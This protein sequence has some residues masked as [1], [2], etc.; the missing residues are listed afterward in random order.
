[1]SGAGPFFRNIM[2]FME[3]KSSL[4]YSQEST[5]D[6]SVNQM[7]LAQ[8]QPPYLFIIPFFI[9]SFHLCLSVPSCLFLS[10]FLS[11]LSGT[12]WLKSHKNH[13]INL[14][15]TQ[16]VS[17]RNIYTNIQ[18]QHTTWEF[19]TAVTA[20]PWAGY[21]LRQACCRFRATTLWIITQTSSPPHVSGVW[22][23]DSMTCVTFCS[24]CVSSK[25]MFWF[26]EYRL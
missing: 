23:L 15:F 25:A 13:T 26:N 2:H 19:R 18:A 16:K 17:L 22:V 11:M 8:V 5:T 3:I 4:L 7:N 14:L 20:W 6:P 24:L 10:R 1:M 12:E 9:L 21:Q